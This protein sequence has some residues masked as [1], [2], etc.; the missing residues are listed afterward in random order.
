M[1]GDNDPPTA[2]AGPNQTVEEKSTIT[3]DGSNSFDPDDGIESYLW[4][5]LAGPVVTFSDPTIDQPTFT[6]PNVGADGVS[7]NFQLTVTDFGGLQ[8]SDT[9]IVNVIGY[10]D[11]PIANAG[12]DQTVIEKSTVTLDGSNSFDPDDGIKSYRWQQVAGSSVTFSD[13]ATDRPTFEAPGNNNMV[14]H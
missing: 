11:P 14:S 5:Q 13:P 7:L 1:T 10:N 6:V 2:N 3:L 8:S 4:K 9:V 12:A